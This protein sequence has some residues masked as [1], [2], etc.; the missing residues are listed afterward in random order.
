M[1]EIDDPILGRLR[2]ESEHW[3]GRT[4]SALL[5]RGVLIKVNSR[6]GPRAI[7]NPVSA[8]QHA[9]LRWFLDHEPD[10]VGTA[11]PAL[12][13]YYVGIWDLEP[14]ALAGP[15]PTT[16]DEIR[17]LFGAPTLRIGVLAAHGP[18]SP[19]RIDLLYKDPWKPG[20]PIVVT[21]RE[22]HSTE[23]DAFA[24]G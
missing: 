10:V 3:V 18:D 4:D 14:G 15:R 23:I 8:R 7:R 1:I 24:E 2:C 17:G 22:D 19:L 5:G 16:F 9:A 12:L 11:E 21:V 20:I 13:G 6:D